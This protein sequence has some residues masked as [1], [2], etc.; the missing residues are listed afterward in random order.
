MNTLEKTKQKVIL[1]SVILII[2]LFLVGRIFLNYVS[3]K[4]IH[5]RVDSISASSKKLFIINVSRYE[6]ILK[7]NLDHIISKTKLSEAMLNKNGKKIDEIINTTYTFEK[8]LNENINVVY[9][10]KITKD[11]YSGFKYINSSFVYSLSKAVYLRDKYVGNIEITVPPEAFLEDLKTIYKIDSINMSSKKTYELDKNMYD[12]TFIT[13]IELKSNDSEVVGNLILHFDISDLINSQINLVHV[14]LY[15]GLII[16][17]LILFFTKKSF[18]SVLKHFKK[19]AF[20]DALTGLG[21]RANLDADIKKDTLNILIL[22]NIKEFSMINEFYGISVGNLV[23]KNV[24]DV[25]RKYADE[26]SMKAYRISSDEF[27]L[28]KYDDSFSEDEYVEILEQMHKKVDYLTI[29]LNGYNDEIQIEIYLGVSNGHKNLVEKAQMALKKA[30]AKSLPYMAYTENIDTREKSLKTI[31]MKKSL[32][33]ALESNNVVPFFQEI[34]NRDKKIIK[35]EALVRI[36]DIEN[37]EEKIL[38][39]DEFLH[40]AIKSGIYIK[41]AL[42]VLK[43]SLVYFSTKEEKISV[44]FLPNDFFQPKVM[45]TFLEIVENFE[46]P[47]NIVIEITEEENIEDFNRLLKIVNMLKKLGVSIAID[48]FGS[49][50]ANYYHILKL[51]PDY[52]KIDGS[53]VKDLLHSEDS[54]ILVKSIVHFAQDLGIKTIAEYV[55]NEEIFEALKRY[56]VDEFQGYYFGKAKN[57]L[58]I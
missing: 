50:Y 43:R 42:E 45:D 41:L 35:Y 49:G 39:P 11:L 57:L 44:N 20:T 21:N 32:K 54:K 34:R 56:G 25:I 38:Y 6:T 23:L 46:N 36:I 10:E 17:I 55:E 37:G 13:N 47:K 51:K 40:V 26:N 15:V 4:L 8:N 24:A 31:N 16:A 2:V 30:K 33:R 19:Q 52:L 28:L 22:G 58:N 3:D 29:D 1:S 12:N 5:E 14:L 18:E 48:D 27:A 9:E 53:I 7:K